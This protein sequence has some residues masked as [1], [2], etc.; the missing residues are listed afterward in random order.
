MEPRDSATL[1][2]IRGVIELDERIDDYALFQFEAL[3][4]TKGAVRI[5]ENSM[6]LY[7][8]R[9]ATTGLILAAWRA[10]I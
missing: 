2:E 9:K 7:S 4:R 5:R 6:H 8:A 3:A 10:G 1:A